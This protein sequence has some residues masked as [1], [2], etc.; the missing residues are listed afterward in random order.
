M[1]YTTDGKQWQDLELVDMDN[2]FTGVRNQYLEVNVKKKTY[3]K[4]LEEWELD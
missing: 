2:Q 3:L 1:Q 4:I